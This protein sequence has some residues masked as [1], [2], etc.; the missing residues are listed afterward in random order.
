MKSVPQRMCVGCREMKT[1]KE[2]I[3]VVRSPQGELFL[4]AVGKMPGRGAYVCPD[5]DCLKKALKNKGLERALNIKI[6]AE[7]WEKIKS[8]IPAES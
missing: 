7:L 8:Q 1:K 6:D 3:R 2:L 5:A 4:D